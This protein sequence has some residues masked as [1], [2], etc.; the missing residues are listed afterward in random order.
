MPGN[1]RLSYIW[2]VV[3]AI[4]KSVIAFFLNGAL[5][6]CE[7]IHKTRLFLF[8]FFRS[9][10]PLSFLKCLDPL[11]VQQRHVVFNLTNAVLDFHQES[12]VR[13][14]VDL[15]NITIIKCILIKGKVLTVETMHPLVKSVEYAVRG[16]LPIRAEALSAVSN[17]IW[18]EGF[19]FVN[20]CVS[21]IEEGSFKVKL[22]QGCFL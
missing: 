14:H 15:W 11:S 3:T 13:F 16:A 18:K 10:P 9:I 12:L 6:L 22:W 7:L 5:R 21:A 4:G 19:F 8:F 17:M 2:H 20:I 1:I